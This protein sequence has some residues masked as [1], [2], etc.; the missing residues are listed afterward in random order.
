MDNTIYPISTKFNEKSPFQLEFRQLKEYYNFRKKFKAERQ[1][2][3][4]KMF[5]N[6]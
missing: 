5:Q 1:Y 2:N 3:V 4:G 6:I